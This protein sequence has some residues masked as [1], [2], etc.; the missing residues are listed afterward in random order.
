MS[1]SIVGALFIMTCNLIFPS[2]LNNGVPFYAEPGRGIIDGALIR[3][4][5]SYH[6]E[7][8]VF[9][10]RIFTTL[11]VVLLANTGLVSSGGAFILVQVLFIALSIYMLLSIGAYLYP[12]KTK[13][14]IASVV[15]FILS[16]TILFAFCTPIYTYDDF[17]QYVFLWEA[18]LFGL[19]KKY[20]WTTLFL[21][22]SLF[23]RESS[24]LLFPS[25]AILFFSD[26]VVHPKKF[27][28]NKTNVF[29]CIALFSFPL[30]VYYIY[31]A[32][33]HG[34]YSD[35]ITENIQYLYTQRFSHFSYNVQNTA[36]AAATLFGIIHVF[37]LPMYILTRS[38]FR[39]DMS[40][41]RVVYTAFI[42]AVAVNTPITLFATRAQEA[43][44]FA[45]P[46]IVLWPYI[47]FYAYQ[48]I[49]ALP[50]QWKTYVQSWKNPRI[51]PV[52]LTD[53]LL[54]SILIFIGVISL[55]YLYTPFFLDAGVRMYQIYTAIVMIIIGLQYM[56]SKSSY[57]INEPS[58]LNESL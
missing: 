24:L 14:Q 2:M 47:G 38:K 26:I 39:R 31:L 34:W 5:V 8:P 20:M 40:Q 18:L 56:I 17:I 32:I 57:Y 6:Q 43:R 29:R 23:V 22:I 4:I 41:A 10:L 13:Y 55:F 30:L 36:F 19:Q 51:V 49:Q 21:S 27:F 15:F 1:I 7:Q 48:L 53:V 12:S 58:R 25:F 54:T 44:I 9:A 35:A 3:D 52:I 16:F 37:L 46:L 50:E 11:P 33:L 28:Y 42:L 45:L